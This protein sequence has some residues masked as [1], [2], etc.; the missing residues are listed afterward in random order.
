L[1]S[2]SPPPPTTLRAPLLI[3]SRIEPECLAL[4]PPDK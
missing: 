1:F 4:T 3:E 2:P